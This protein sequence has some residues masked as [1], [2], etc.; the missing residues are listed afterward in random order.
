MERNQQEKG[1][2]LILIA[3]AAVGLFAFGALAIDGSRLY[4]DKRHAQNAADTSA[5]AAALA[6]GRGSDAT[7]AAIDR[8]LSNGYDDNGTTNNVTV[9]INDSPTGVCPLNVAGKDFTVDIVSTID[10][11]FARVLGRQTVTTAV[12]ATSRTCGSYEGPPFDGNAIIALAPSGIGFDA[13]GNTSVTVT[14]GGILSNSNTNPSVWCGGSASVIAPSITTAGTPNVSGCYSGGS[15]PAPM[16]QIPPSTYSA[17]FPRE[18]ACDGTATYTTTSSG[19]NY[20]PE[21]GKDGSKL[22]LGASGAIDFAPGLYCIMDSTIG[23]FH[24]QIT[25]TG[26]TF[27][28]PSSSFELKLNAVNT[29]FTASAPTSGEY[30]GVLFYM[31]PVF[32]SSGNLVNQQALDI[33]GN[34]NTDIVGSIIA[35]S[36]DITMYANSNNRA[37]NSQIIAYQ[38]DN[39]GG[40]LVSIAYNPNDNFI[41]R[42]PITLTMLK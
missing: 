1:Q 30:A 5:M 8:A 34:G 10:T 24:G 28:V 7:T 33:R 40:A 6:H 20:Q 19:R 23:P 12:T 36:A 17:L 14:G 42:L 41:L 15:A 11:T 31:R 18:P 29:T 13:H 16:P 9:T 22:D 27:F 26:V 2:A 38:V 39:Q 4:S 25:G 35:P 21:P 32:D 3:L 37:I